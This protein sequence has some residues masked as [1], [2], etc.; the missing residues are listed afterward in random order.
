M[1]FQSRGKKKKKK[2]DAERHQNE[3]QRRGGEA[4]ANS[5]VPR[6]LCKGIEIHVPEMQLSILLGGMLSRA[7]REVRDGVSRREFESNDEERKGGRWRRDEEER[8]EGNDARVR[9]TIGDG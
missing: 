5:N 1:R 9:K 3:E 7:R 8:D 2:Y 4:N 6:V